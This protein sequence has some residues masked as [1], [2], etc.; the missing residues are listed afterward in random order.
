MKATGIVRRIDDLGR[1]VIPMELRK[2]FGIESGTPL[3]I[4]TDTDSIIFKKYNI[5]EK[6]TDLE[7]KAVLE[8]ID[9]NKVRELG[10]QNKVM[11]MLRLEKELHH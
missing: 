11:E 10:L 3:E 7:K 8:C 1:V 9:M 6:L 2:A 4:Y 5:V